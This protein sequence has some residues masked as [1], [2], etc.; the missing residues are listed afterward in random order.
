MSE[1]VYVTEDGLAKMKEELNLLVAIERPNA[2][3]AIAEA[4]EKGDLSENAEYDAAK[5]AQGL[6]ELRIRK[7]EAE[8]GNARVLDATKIDITKVSVLSKVKVMNMKMK[9]EFTYHLVSEAE[10]DLKQMKISVKSPI[11]AALL[12]LKKGEKVTIQ[13][14]AGAMELQVLDIS[15]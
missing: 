4:R 1:I 9:K 6:L 8:I 13:I 2:S 11:G 7:L 12:G 3:K 5:E 15:I 14:P 10:A